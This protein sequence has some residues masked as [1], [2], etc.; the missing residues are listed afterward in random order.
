MPSDQ[1]NPEGSASPAEAPAGAQLRAVT[2]MF[3][4]LVGS[5][6]LYQDRGDA[7]ARSL[8]QK[9]QKLLLSQVKKFRGTL[10]KTIG[11]GLIVSFGKPKKAV[12]CAVAM[13]RAM[14]AYNRRVPPADQLHIRI[15]V[16]SGK[17]LVEQSDIYGDVVNTA[18][19]IEGRAA[20]DEI[21]TSETT[22]EGCSGLDT[23]VESLG[24][25]E[26]RGLAERITLVRVLWH[27]ERIEDLR[28]RMVEDQLLPELSDALVRN[29]CVLVLGGLSMGPG[30]GSLQ[31]RVAT[32]LAEE[33][34]VDERRRMLDQLAATYEEE[35]DRD[36]LLELVSREIE[37]E[38]DCVPELLSALAELPFTIILT[39]DLDTRL[40][41]ALLEAGKKVK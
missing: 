6:R 23:E 27:P 40:E 21:I 8:V 41:R 20:G 5:T 35:N 3:T 17:G 9:H 25:C 2:V 16:H 15:G 12:G 1:N 30:K 14:D 7:V 34:G 10:H 24:E 28:G 38:S 13:Q 11:D 29:K 18:A 37:R 36:D 22:W 26:L 33:Q 39:T 19:R 31:E 4:D 32:K